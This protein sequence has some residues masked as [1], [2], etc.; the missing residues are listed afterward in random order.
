MDFPVNT[1]PNA[2]AFPSPMLIKTTGMTRLRLP[3][4][5][6]GRAGGESDTLIKD[7]FIKTTGMTRLRPPRADYG[8]AGGE[9]D[10][11]T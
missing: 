3:R 2:I 9:S 6:Y 1:S 11:I 4:A 7:S 10:T 5:D 8:R